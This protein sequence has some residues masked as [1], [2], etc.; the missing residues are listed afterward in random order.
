MQGLAGPTATCQ[1]DGMDATKNRVQDAVRARL[2]QDPR[3][4]YAEKISVESLHDAVTLRG[5]VGNF[6]Q[7]RAAVADAR[8][9]PGVRDVW[10]EL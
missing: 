7:Q 2:A 6:A 8:R 9:T 3:L 5:T 1:Q 10:D 4:P